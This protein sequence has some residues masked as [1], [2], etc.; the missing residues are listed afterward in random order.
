MAAIWSQPASRCCCLRVDMRPGLYINR[1]VHRHV[2]WDEECCFVGLTLLAPTP[3]LTLIILIL[4]PMSFLILILI[5]HIGYRSI[6]ADSW[7]WARKAVASKP[8][9]NASSNYMERIQKRDDGTERPNANPQ[10]LTLDPG[11]ICSRQRRHSATST[12]VLRAPRRGH[13]TSTVCI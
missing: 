8:S 10:T 11:T 1:L 2:L 13:T 4:I 3:A 7:C 9:L 12:G 5:L 6:S